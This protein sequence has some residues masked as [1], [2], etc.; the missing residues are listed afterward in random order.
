M[1]EVSLDL[2][3]ANIFNK[4]LHSVKDEA[5]RIS[6]D[7]RYYNPSALKKEMSLTVTFLMALNFP[8]MNSP[9]SSVWRQRKFHPNDELGLEN[10]L[11]AN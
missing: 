3:E 1:N 7:R 6:Q 9:P 10:A 11:W 2:M 5:T 4:H 8:T